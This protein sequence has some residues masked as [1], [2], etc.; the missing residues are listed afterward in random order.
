MTEPRTVTL[1]TAD[2]G[3]VVLTEPS[4]C[5]GHQLHDPETLR[6]DITHAGPSVDCSHLGADL[7]SA[8]LVQSPHSESTNPLLGGR[9]PG[10]SVWPIGRTLDPVQLY[11]LAADLDRYADQLRGLADQLATVLDGGESR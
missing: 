11:S 1:P 5:A 3:D 6:V 8:E 2:A 4:W 9:T 10:V 7:F